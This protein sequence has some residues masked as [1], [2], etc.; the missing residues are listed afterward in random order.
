[1]FRHLDNQ[2]RETIYKKYV[3][4]PELLKEERPALH[5]QWRD[6]VKYGVIQDTITYFNDWLY[7]LIFNDIPQFDD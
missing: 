3:N 2:D 1:M 4:N 5:S 7:K 6:E